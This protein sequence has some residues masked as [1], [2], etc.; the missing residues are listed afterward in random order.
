M[1]TLLTITFHFQTEVLFGIKQQITLQ[2][3]IE[4]QRI[5]QRSKQYKCGRVQAPTFTWAATASSHT[6]H[7]DVIWTC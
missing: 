1:L 4:I 6:Q 2:N 7:Y 5:P 3:S